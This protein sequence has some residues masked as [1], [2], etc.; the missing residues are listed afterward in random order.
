[1][2]E[3]II[4]IA[5]PIAWLGLAALYAWYFDRHDAK[6]KSDYEIRHAMADAE[7]AAPHDKALR[8]LDERER[9]ARNRRAMI[10]GRMKELGLSGCL[11]DMGWTYNPVTRHYTHPDGHA[12]TD[13]A[14][15]ADAQT[16][17]N[18]WYLREDSR[19]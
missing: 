5:V 6:K 13:V 14:A 15:Q 10:Q 17:F 19:I 2:L 16:W 9:V 7:Q 11:L 4:L 12:M 1:M 18:T 8:E 3:T